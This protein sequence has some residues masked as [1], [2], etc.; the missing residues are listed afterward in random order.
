MLKSP[1]WRS[2]PVSTLNMP[3]TSSPCL[4]PHIDGNLHNVVIHEPQDL[5]VLRFSHPVISV[6]PPQTHPPTTPPL[7]RNTP[8]NNTHHIPISMN[9][10]AMSSSVGP[11][12]SPCPLAPPLAPAP[13]PYPAKAQPKPTSMNTGAMSSSVSPR[14]SLNLITFSASSPLQAYGWKGDKPTNSGL[15]EWQHAVHS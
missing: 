10:G 7:R 15:R 2:H 9:T 11:R 6:R 14:A 4:A 3:H 13:P 1:N 5:L 8:S 12:A